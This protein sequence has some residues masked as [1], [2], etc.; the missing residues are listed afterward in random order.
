MSAEFTRIRNWAHDRNLLAGST[1]KD[2]FVKLLEEVGE[3]ANGIR[4]TDMLEIKD[5][6]GD[7]CV[8]LTIIAAQYGLDIEDCIDHAWDQI[9]DRRGKL[10]NG[11]FVKET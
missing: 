3:L 10:I 11:V 2:Q 6:L 5:G 4:K 1:P 9:K 7:V 8:V